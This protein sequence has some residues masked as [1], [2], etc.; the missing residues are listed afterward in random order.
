MTTTEHLQ[1]IKA[2]CEQLIAIYSQPKYSG[3]ELMIAG[4]KATIAAIDGLSELIKHE[5]RFEGTHIGNPV[6]LNYERKII[7]AILSAWPEEIL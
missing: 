5:E 1:K 2:K 4:W 6:E 7:T 3:M